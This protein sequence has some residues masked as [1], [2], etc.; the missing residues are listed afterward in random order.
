MSIFVADALQLNQSDSGWFYFIGGLIRDRAY[1]TSSTFG[2]TS[3]SSRSS[4][5]KRNASQSVR[6]RLRAAGGRHAA[7]ARHAATADNVCCD[8]RGASQNT[9][10]YSRRQCAGEPARCA[11]HYGRGPPFRLPSPNAEPFSKRKKSIC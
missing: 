1:P 7:L 9:P 11:R 5:A 6:L 4:R 10:I 8:G 3:N 2:D